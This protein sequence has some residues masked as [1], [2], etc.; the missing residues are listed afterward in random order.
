MPF[1]LESKHDMLV[2]FLSSC[3]LRFLLH[4]R[5]HL[6]KNA[7]K[8]NDIFQ[9]SF[10]MLSIKMLDFLLLCSIA[11]LEFNPIW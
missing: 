8:M 3:D 5:N 9:F 7:E 11:I 2:R 10:D 6:V 4:R 1:V